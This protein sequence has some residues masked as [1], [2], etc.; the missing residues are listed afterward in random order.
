[1]VAAAAAVVRLVYALTAAPSV[2]PADDDGFFH[3]AGAFIANGDGYIN[4]GALV[5]G[6]RVPT[7]L[8]PPLYP[9][10]IAG[11]TE[12][13]ITDDREQ[14]VILGT[15]LG[16]GVVLAVAK[17]GRLLFGWR[18][19][20]LAAGLA[21][22]Y[23]TLIAADGVEM[24]ETLYG[25]LVALGLVAAVRLERD[26]SAARA[27]ALGLL[28]GLAA[29]TRPEALLL[30]VL[31]SGVLLISARVPLRRLAL[32]GLVTLA[33]LAPW[34]VRNAVT[35]NQPVLSTNEALLL[36]GTNCPTVYSGPDI[37]WYGFLCAA[38]LHPTPS[39]SEAEEADRLR[40]EALRYARDHVDRLP[41]VIA[42]RL[43]RVWGLYQ[44]RRQAEALVRNAPVEGAARRMAQA[45]ILLFYPLCVLAMAGAA[46]TLRRRTELLLIATP[47][48]AT[49]IVAMA[50]WGTPRLRHVAELSV[51]VL[52]ASA[53]A[54]I[55]DRRGIDRG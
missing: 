44:P 16:T 2:S 1:V 14:R 28:M 45:G 19:G 11:L 38:T 17:I 31:I 35:F 15:V 22:L 8:H 33:V 25:L 12:I 30:L 7:A 9:L 4:F 50:S 6:H 41:G 46:L 52:A 53:S 24:T 13:G 54:A 55:L 3:A 18:A 26:R 42:V 48:A 36:A 5:E 37:G 34:L 23:P 32:S 20:L 10:L 21:A 43:L 39:R 40:A 49:S 27:A 29:L 51:V 47:I